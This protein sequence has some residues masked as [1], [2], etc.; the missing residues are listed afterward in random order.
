MKYV[1]LIPDGCADLPVK[2]LGNRTPMQA[3][4]T[5]NFDALA[6]TGI[7]GR[8]NNV[9]V[10]LAPGSDVATLGLL[11]YHPKRYY[12]G[13]APLE[14][15]ALGIP[16][17]S[18]DWV[19]RCNLVY[20]DGGIMRSFTAGHIP[21][22]EAAGLIDVLNEAVVP[23]SPVPLWFYA[24]VSY[25][26]LALVKD[27]SIF[28]RETKTYP[29]HD[30]TD[31]SIGPALPAGPGSKLLMELMEHSKKA[32][33]RHPINRKRMERNKLPCSQVWLW[34]LGQKPEVPLFA[35]QHAAALENKPFRGAMITAVD[36]LRGIAAFIG[37]DEINVPRATGYV[38]TDYAAKGQY[39]SEALDKYDIVC[40]HVEATDES[41]HEGD[42][43]KKT[44]ALEDI[45]A[46]LLPPVLDALKHN[47]EWRILIS[48]DH[49]TP[50]SLKTHTSDYVPWLIAG[51]G[52]TTSEH[53]ADS[54]NE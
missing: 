44:K 42:A 5:P 40:I 38:D 45:D 24:G 27:S 37:W 46:K 31:K 30:F 2:S 1:I 29:P 28:L 8:S 21:S 33:E 12:T 10:E 50:C 34:G 43:E 52:I 48:P 19:I 32:F 14:A 11:G 23:F 3:A 20:I 6:K 35:E 47:G 25:R 15:A 39:A 17:R 4:R 54:Y 22:E 51:S 41:G 9:P 7:I 16:F 49:P 18:D 13:R 36:L 53:S 26:N